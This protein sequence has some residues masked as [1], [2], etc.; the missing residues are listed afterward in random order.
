MIIFESILTTFKL[1]I[2]SIGSWGNSCA[3]KLESK[4]EPRLWNLACP[5][6]WNALQHIPDFDKLCLGKFAY[7]D[8]L[9]GL[10]QF[11]KLAQL[12]QKMTLSLKSGQ[13]R[14]EINRLNLYV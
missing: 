2:V 12:D 8:F 14:L 3:N 9:L 4:I 7:A 11:S 6:P 5:N 13:K 10:S 1:S